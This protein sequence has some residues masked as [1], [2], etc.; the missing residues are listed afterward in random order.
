MSAKGRAEYE[1]SSRQRAEKGGN[2][3]GKGKADGKG[4][5]Q[6]LDLSE[7]QDGQV[8]Q[9]MVDHAKALMVAMALLTVS[10][11]PRPVEVVLHFGEDHFG[12][13]RGEQIPLHP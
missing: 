11:A 1:E 3:R 4:K 5:A 10:P 13:V 6:R 7:A 2:A 8:P 9:E 12:V